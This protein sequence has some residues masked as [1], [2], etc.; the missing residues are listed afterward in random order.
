[1]SRAERSPGRTVCLPPAGVLFC[2]ALIL[3]GFFQLLQWPIVSY[4][5]DLWFHLN[6]GQ[7][8]FEHGRIT[9]GSYFSFIDPPYT[10]HNYLWLFQVLIY[11]VFS[12]AGY[13]GLVVVRAVAFLALTAILLIFL[14]SRRRGPSSL[15]SWPF[16]I[17]YFLCPFLLPR[18][19]LVRPH[20]FTYFGTVLALYIL[21]FR[22][23][24][25]WILPVLAIVWCNIHG[26]TYPV[27]L[28]ILGAYALERLWRWRSSPPPRALMVWILLAAACVLLTP[29]GAAL[30][31]IPFMSIASTS[32]YIGELRA[33]TLP[34]VVSFKVQV[35]TPDTPTVFNVLAFAVV[36]SA[37][38][39]LRS[40]SLR[41]SHA[42]CAAAGAYLLTK[43]NR[44]M[45]EFV[46][47]SLPLL[48]A[49]PPLRPG[50]LQRVLPGPLFLSL[51]TGVMLM[52]MNYLYAMFGDR[53]AYPFSFR[54]LPHGVTA[55]LQ[56]VDVGGHVL[57]PANT[58]GFHRWRL[59]P[60][61]KIHMNL[62]IPYLFKDVDCYLN[63]QAFQNADTLRSLVERYGIDFISVDVNHG[64]FPK[65][66]GEL[67]QFAPVFFD[68]V[69]VLYVNRDAHPEIAER[70][71]LR[72]VDPFTLVKDGPEQFLGLEDEEL[73][74]PPSLDWEAALRELGAVMALHPGCGIVNQLFAR[75]YLHEG[76]FDR[77]L[78]F[79]ERI[80]RY[81]P[82]MAVGY[83]LKGRALHG[84]QL[85]ERALA[86]YRLAVERSGESLWLQR[87]IGLAELAQQRYGRAYAALRKAI[88][89]TSGLTGYKDVYTLAQ[90]ALKAGKP[91]EAK[92]LLEVLQYQVPKDD[93]DLRALVRRE[94]DQLG[95]T[96]E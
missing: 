35:L 81:Y 34:D 24:S 44:F 16:V 79:A 86:A 51:A 89:T 53:P 63:G 74:K 10:W 27:L 4:D 94:L 50:T 29:H 88:G 31:R 56:H 14:T 73:K 77:A 90:T 33:V 36:L 28:V 22:P 3:T 5:T 87:A 82:E 21:E 76:A 69:E 20:I 66:I 47:L 62:E 80:I 23:A 71:Q 11:G 38:T 49:H 13:G 6:G 95:S 84:L 67:P 68:D 30:L 12:M 70:Y 57:N 93:P 58:G 7:Y 85:E 43:G 52:G 8:F 54:A 9:S 59:W 41:I 37:L 60:R 48:R 45:Y 92:E 91:A 32:R 15:L 96:S 72:V 75:V 46:L 65:F 1:M 55:F 64:K 25:A 78:P 61:Y 2:L 42:V 17:F 83:Y 40:R 26:I 19:M 18:I 39:A